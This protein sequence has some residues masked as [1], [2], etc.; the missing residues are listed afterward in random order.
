MKRFIIMVLIIALLLPVSPTKSGAAE[1]FDPYK[2][3]EYIPVL[4]VH[5]YNDE[6]SSWEAA[7]IYSY[8]NIQGSPVVAVDYGEYNRNDITSDTIQQRMTDA[9][10]KL[11]RDAQF[12]IIVHSM[13]GL[14]TRYYFTQHPE[15][16]KRVR[17]VIFMGTPNHGSQ[18][19]FM[20][21]IQTMFDDP[22]DYFQ[23]GLDNKEIQKYRGYY[24]D[25]SNKMM[26]SWNGGQ[27]PSQPYEEWLNK[28][29]TEVIQTIKGRQLTEA[30]LNL[31]KLGTDVLE[32]SLDYR[33]SGAFEEY[34][35]LM[36]GRVLEREERSRGQYSLKPVFKDDESD[37]VKLVD[38]NLIDEGTIV[39]ELKA[40]CW[41]F[42]LDGQQLSAKNVVQDR[43]MS[44]R[45]Y[46]LNHIDEDGK[47]VKESVISN[48]FLHRLWLDESLYRN[49]TLRNNGY[50]PQY[51]TV[52]TVDDPYHL[53]GRY[54]VDRFIKNISL[55][56]AEENDAVVPL[57]SVK[58]EIW[59]D[60]EVEKNMDRNLRILPDLEMADD[61]EV[62]EQL[63]PYIYHSDQM[64]ETEIIK[65][66]VEN[67]LTGKDDNE[68]VMLLNPNQTISKSGNKIIV[69]EDISYY[70]KPV[71]LKVSSRT[72][73]NVRIMERDQYQT[74]ERMVPV[75]MKWI[76]NNQW[77]GEF[78]YKPS[79]EVKDVLVFADTEVTVSYEPALEEQPVPEYP[80]YI[81][82]LDSEMKDG[83]IIHTFRVIDRSTGNSVAT[84]DSTDF[85]AKLNGKPLVNPFI[86]KNKKTLMT[87]GSILMNLDYS[88]SMDGYP[89][90]IS[91]VYAERYISSLQ[92]KTEAKVGIIGF[93]D[94][95]TVLQ[96]LTLDYQEASKRV[97]TNISGGTSL[98]DSI[99]A[100]ARLLSYE[101][102]RKSMIL[103]TDGNESGSSEATMEEAVQ[104]AK[105]NNLALYIVALGLTD[106]NTLQQ[107]A[108]QTGGKLMYSLSPDDLIEAYSTV[109][110]EE[111]YVYTLQYDVG[112]LSQANTLLLRM[113][114]D[115]SNEAVAEYA[116]Y[117]LM[118]LEWPWEKLSSMVADI[119]EGYWLG[120]SSY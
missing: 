25:Y 16:Q 29:H 75:P 113:T 88:S 38:R 64:K 81:Q 19:A 47:E 53:I 3:T 12:D 82:M 27:I 21:R 87:S 89:K 92:N 57:S 105:A 58:L 112:N 56:D 52:A 118:Y 33:Y 90:A 11:P 95:I 101:A 28:N 72:R 10:N 46:L 13:G 107:I 73:A 78:E 67:P 109:T 63:G 111:D 59:P 97:Y 69:R 108:D 115:R 48:L 117:G 106:M 18:A 54:P 50:L 71:K 45:F 93:T 55:W 42:C 76:E 65:K 24:Q 68:L 84:L 79:D 51:I 77:E 32:G 30:G 104:A 114:D 6:A 98:Y 100:G 66:Q 31:S 103:M 5:G 83:R 70:G 96:T 102:G 61:K 20:N 85:V 37:S 119:K 91:K 86:T 49:S 62:E 14:L 1:V 8:L 110:E 116:S 23:D 34:A 43:L 7:E 26:E 60:L 99:V 35:K 120:N 80:Y 17:R 40:R 36:L 94:M 22:E 74:W 15:I 9:I 39:S 4:F 44:E 2:T 41:G